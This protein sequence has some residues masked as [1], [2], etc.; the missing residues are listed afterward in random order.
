MESRHIPKN[1]EQSGKGKMC[2]SD[3]VTAESCSVSDEDVPLQEDKYTGDEEKPCLFKGV[4]SDSEDEL[5][6]KFVH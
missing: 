4:F 1:F 2:K 5:E 6:T 3:S